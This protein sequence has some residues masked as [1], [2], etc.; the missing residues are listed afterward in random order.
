MKSRP[1]IPQKSGIYCIKN[2]TN[3]K[4]YVGS[5]V[6][7]QKRRNTHFRILRNGNHANAPLQYAWK[8]YQESSFEFVV[9]E[10]VDDPQLLVERE[11]C[12]LDALKVTDRQYG[13]NLSPTAGS[14]LG[15][16]HSEE[17]KAKIAASVANVSEERRVKISAALKGRKWTEA[18]RQ[19]STGWKHT[20]E[21]KAK[22]ST[23]VKAYN[24]THERSPE[25]IARVCEARRN[26]PPFTEETK[27]KMRAWHA[28]RPPASDKAKAKRSESLLR[29]YAAKNGVPYETY[30]LH[31][32][33]SHHKRIILKEE[34]A[35]IAA[36]GP[37]MPDMGVE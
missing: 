26:R 12:W 29:Y 35:R 18:K 22:M 5:A 30:V 37:R 31:P 32:R 34:Q 19:K 2:K 13:Y 11:Q 27:A 9:L 7:L 24:A 16:K 1:P 10:F 28:T 15:M 14:Q 4:V 6:N 25:T 3:G 23:A 17:T 36:K 33:R 8:K 20:D 21:A